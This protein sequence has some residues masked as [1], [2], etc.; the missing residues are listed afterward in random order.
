MIP[1]TVASMLVYVGQEYGPW[2][3]MILTIVILVLFGGVLEGAPALIIFGPIL[4]PIAIQ[5]GFS[6]LHFGVV[7]VISMGF[8]LFCPP[9]GIGLYTTCTVA[10]V[11]MKNIVKPMRKYLMVSFAGILLVTFVPQLATWLPSIMMK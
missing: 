3:F 10:R 9:I 8:G 7:M 2:I 11:E 1:H 4:V 6:P 5:L